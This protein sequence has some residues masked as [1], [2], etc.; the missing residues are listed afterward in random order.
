MCEGCV[1]LVDAMMDGVRG[2]QKRL[3]LFRRR[4]PKTAELVLDS[5]PRPAFYPVRLKRRSYLEREVRS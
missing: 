2:R 1:E 3:A 5:A 4:F